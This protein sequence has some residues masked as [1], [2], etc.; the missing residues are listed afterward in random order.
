MSLA[1]YRPHIAEMRFHLLDRP[2]HPEFFS[3]HKSHTIQRDKYSAKFCITSDGHYISWRA[4]DVYLTEI[5]AS[6]TQPVPDRRLLDLPLRNQKNQQL[7]CAGS[8]YSY[9]FTLERVPADMFWMIQ[10]QLGSATR[11]H[12][13][14]HEF[15]SSGRLPIGGLSYIHVESRLQQLQVQAIH[16]FPDDYTLVKTQTTFRCPEV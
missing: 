15:N 13:L 3:V 9:E 10:K 16:T 5:A 7:Q 8:L 12:E 4:G 2:V 11:T 1:G 6:V 14:I